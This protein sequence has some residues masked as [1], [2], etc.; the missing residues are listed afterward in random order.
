M[1]LKAPSA[2]RRFIST[3][4]PLSNVNRWPIAPSLAVDEDA[5]KKEEME[6][7]STNL[8]TILH[9]EFETVLSHPCGYEI[10]K[11]DVSDKA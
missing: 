2:I 8:P 4:R 3:C 5:K 9:K 10:G 1:T 6:D 7:K 11:I